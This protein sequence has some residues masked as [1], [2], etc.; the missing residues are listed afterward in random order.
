MDMY[1]RASIREQY[2]VTSHYAIMVDWIG[3]RV[4]AG[5]D[6]VAVVLQ[7]A[8][9]SFGAGEFEA[10]FYWTEAASEIVG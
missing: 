8:L 4:D 10:A 1:R 5:D 3:Q 7:A 9:E 6:M 2:P